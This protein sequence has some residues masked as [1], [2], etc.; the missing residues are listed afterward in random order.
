M[1]S[2]ADGKADFLADRLSRYK[3]PE[4]SSGVASACVTIPARFA[5]PCCA[6][7]AGG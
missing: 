3:H 2:V 4:A 1:R 6:R 5:A 7:R